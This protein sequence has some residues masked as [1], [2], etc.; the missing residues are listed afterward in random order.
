[1]GCGVVTLASQDRDELR[2]G[3]EE[4][5]AFAEAL[6]LAVEGHWPGAVPVAQE[7]LVGLGRQAA[8]VR[9]LDVGGKRIG[10]AVAGL[11]GVGDLGVLLG[12]G[13]VGDPA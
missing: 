1:M 13:A 3:V 8:H 2:A 7:A 11:D 10:V 5:A 12:H 9:P 6:E 4:A